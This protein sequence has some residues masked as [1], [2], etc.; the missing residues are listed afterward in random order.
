M[1]A[2]SG[3]SAHQREHL[4]GS[5]CGF[6]RLAELRFAMGSAMLQALKR[7]MRRLALKEEQTSSPLIGK[8][9]RSF[10]K[11]PILNEHLWALILQHLDSL[12]DHVKASTSCRAAWKAGLL[13]VNVPVN[14]PSKGMMSLSV[15]IYLG[16]C[17]SH[18]NM[19][20]T[21][22]TCLGHHEGQAR[23]MNGLELLR[24]NAFPGGFRVNTSSC[25]PCQ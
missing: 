14:L 20:G 25:T 3:R 24:A 13:K 17:F 23:K 10:P 12:K 21:I 1:Y 2:A 19:I 8:G 6:V 15:C 5:C 4:S 9:K 22:L 18:M 11:G 7:R 16:L